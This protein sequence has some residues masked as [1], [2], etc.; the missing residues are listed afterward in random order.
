M[1]QLIYR[2]DRL[3]SKL[4]TEERKKRPRR[5][6]ERGTIGECAIGNGKD[7]SNEQI[8]SILTEIFSNAE[9]PCRANVVAFGFVFDKTV[10]GVCV[11]PV[12]SCRG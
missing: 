8:Q 12:G 6:I 7:F 5:L 2:Q 10:I 4:K 3:V 11:Y 1:K 9:T